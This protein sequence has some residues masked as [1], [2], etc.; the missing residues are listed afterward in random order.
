METR[1]EENDGLILMAASQQLTFTCEED[2][3]RGKVAYVERGRGASEGH[4]SAPMCTATT[5]KVTRYH[6]ADWLGGKY[7][8]LMER[9]TA[10]INQALC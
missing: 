3:S 4:F 7:L 6:G 10:A 5:Q 1:Q 2:A 9:H 8:D